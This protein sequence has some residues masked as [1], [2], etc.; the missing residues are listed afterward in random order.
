MPRPDAASPARPPAAARHREAQPGPRPITDWARGRLTRSGRTAAAP[1][2]AARHREL[3][4][5][6]VE[7]PNPA[8][9]VDAARP[10][11][12]AGPDGAEGEYPILAGSA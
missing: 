12:L 10:A 1:K 4:A 9:E 2:P 8:A 3:E 6:A 7:R 5:A 11:A